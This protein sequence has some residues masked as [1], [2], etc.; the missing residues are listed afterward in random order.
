MEFPL[1]K[2]LDLQTTGNFKNGDNYT[3]SMFFC[4]NL[5]AIELKQ[6]T[7]MY[8]KLNL[9]ERKIFINSILNLFDQESLRNLNLTIESLKHRDF[10]VNSKYNSLKGKISAYI[11]EN[12]KTEKSYKSLKLPPITESHKIVSEIRSRSKNQINSGKNEPIL[13]SSQSRIASTRQKSSVRFNLGSEL[14]EHRDRNRDLESFIRKKNILAL[15]EAYNFKIRNLNV[16]KSNTNSIDLNDD[17]IIK[18]LKLYFRE[19]K[20]ANFGKKIQDRNSKEKEKEFLSSDDEANVEVTK[21]LNNTKNNNYNQNSGIKCSIYIKKLRSNFYEKKLLRSLGLNTE[22]SNKFNVYTDKTIRNYNSDFNLFKKFDQKQSVVEINFEKLGSELFNDEVSLN[23]VQ[24]MVLKNSLNYRKMYLNDIL[25]Y[26]TKIKNWS[27]PRIETLIISLINDN[28]SNILEFIRKVVEKRLEPILATIN[29]LPDHILLKIFSNLDDESLSK[30]CL[31]CKRWYYLTNTQ[32]LWFFKC[33]TLGK[34]E[35]LDQIE[36]E[37]INELYVDEDIDWKMAYYEIKSFIN[38][39]KVK[40]LVQINSFYKEKVA[41][42]KPDSPKSFLSHE[43]NDTEYENFYSL[44]KHNKSNTNSGLSSES[45]GEQVKTNDDKPKTTLKTLYFD[46]ENNIHIEYDPEDQFNQ[47]VVNELIDYTEIRTD[48]NQSN[49][50]LNHVVPNYKL[51]W[52]FED[53]SINSINSKEKVLFRVNSIEKVIYLKDHRNAITCMDFDKKRLVTGGKDRIIYVYDLKDGNKIGKL[54]GHKGGIQCLQLLSNRV[55]SGSWDSSVIIWNMYTFEKVVTIQTNFDSITSLYFDS[56]YLIW[57]SLDKS[58]NVWTFVK[59][60]SEKNENKDDFRIDQVINFQCLIN[61]H[62][63]GVKS[64]SYD[65]LGCIISADISGIVLISDTN[66]NLIKELT[67]PKYSDPITCLRLVGALIITSTISGRVIFW[68]RR[69]NTCETIIKCHD[70]A[71][72][73]I[74]FYDQKFYTAGRDSFIKEWDLCTFTCLR[75]LK[76]HENSVLDILVMENKII[77]CDSDKV[78]LWF[79]KPKK[80][81]SLK[82]EANQENSLKN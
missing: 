20:F 79:M 30:T 17:S 55:C 78:I 38:E 65:G 33:K 10:N 68:N 54:V 69:S 29:H 34:T 80:I 5:E 25:D 42:L 63:A 23:N 3:N 43:S 15:D 24:K 22:R 41:K 37:L 59:G 57:G 18:K 9:S 74:A 53:E 49:D 21:I 45:V 47:E 27:I 66:G 46:L 44:T 64:L 58:I 19:K 13:K 11:P 26:I 72:N 14:R 52:K 39:L 40:Y 70:S 77:T 73:S 12:F 48:L 62:K 2:S 75:K 82:N 31:V 56:R 16:P 4:D 71:I 1:S 32:E 36:F 50:I 51:R 61:H 67:A 60:Y 76:A 81:D 6:I 35:H 28:S 8:L 7:K